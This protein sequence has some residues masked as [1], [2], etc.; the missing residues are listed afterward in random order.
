MCS[1]V[2]EKTAS[3]L[4]AKGF[5]A[6]DKANTNKDLFADHKGDEC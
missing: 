5:Q 4:M 2:K 1:S 6:I 3:H